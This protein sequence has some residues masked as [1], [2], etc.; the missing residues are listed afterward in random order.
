MPY[1]QV[2]MPA[3]LS[4]FDLLANIDN[5]DAVHAG[6]LVSHVICTVK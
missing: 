1:Q 6:R 5:S 3:C 4:Q 2:A